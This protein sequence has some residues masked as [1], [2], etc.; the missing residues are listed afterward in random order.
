[1][2]EKVGGGG[3]PRIPPEETILVKLL[4]NRQSFL[5]ES[6]PVEERK[7]K[8]QAQTEF[9][10][11]L[12]KIRQPRQE[13]DQ[14]L[15]SVLGRYLLIDNIPPTVQR[16]LRN[17]A[18]PYAEFGFTLEEAIEFSKFAL[19]R[20]LSL[21]IFLSH[22]NRTRRILQNP[23]PDSNYPCLIAH[24]DEEAVPVLSEIEE[25]YKQ[26]VQVL[27]SNFR[28][29]VDRQ[30]NLNEI[31]DATSYFHQ[32]KTTLEN[33]TDSRILTSWKETTQVFLE[34]MM[35]EGAL[36]FAKPTY[37]KK[38]YNRFVIAIH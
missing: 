27:Y 34:F 31:Q 11:A 15:K 8:Q 1:M 5:E 23:R 22:C 3:I 19:E 26:G 14:K 36:V 32:A 33:L 37:Y 7:L 35:S 38:R 12:A 17:Y 25:E 29:S 10:A 13:I 6:D 2:I 30:D 28:H 18:A 24:G 21:E 16:S 4:K 9:N 20:D